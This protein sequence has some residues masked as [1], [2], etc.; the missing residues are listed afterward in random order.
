VSGGASP[1]LAPAGTAYEAAK[2]RWATLADTQRLEQLFVQAYPGQQDSSGPM[3]HWL[4]RGG[5]LLLEDQAGVPLCAVRWRETS[6]GWLVDRVA[7]L[8]QA[9]G[10]G[11]DRW[12]MT[13]VEALAIRYNIPS[14]SVNLP[15]AEQAGYYRR[16]GYSPIDAPVGVPEHEPGQRANRAL[17]VRKRVG[18]TWQMQEGSRS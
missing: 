18:G 11:F 14:L 1:L 4:E 12:L 8:P 17:V 6:D 9:K 2:L 10:M 3:A 7:T 5:G 13:K 16:L 15:D